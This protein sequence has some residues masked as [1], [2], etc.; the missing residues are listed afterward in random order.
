MVKNVNTFF[1]ILFAFFNMVNASVIKA[2]NIK[3]KHS[4]ISQLEWTPGRN[5]DEKTD[6]FWEN[7]SQEVNP[8]FNTQSFEEILNKYRKNF[9]IKSIGK[10]VTINNKLYPDI[11]NYVPNGFVESW[12]KTF[13]TSLR[14]I[15]QTRH[16]SP[17]IASCHDGVLDIDFNLINYEKFS[18]NPKVN[19]QSISNRGTKIGEGIS[20]GFKAAKYISPK[21]SFA[22]GG[23]NIIHF[24]DTIDLG[25]NFYLVSS[26]YIPFAKKKSDFPS[27]VFVNAGIGSDFFGYKGN[28]FL[29]TTSCLGKPTL[30]GEGTEKCNWG[31]IGSVAFVFNERFSLINEWFGYSYGT[32]FSYR[33]IKNSSLVLSLFATDFIKGYPRYASEGCPNNNCSTRYYGSFSLSI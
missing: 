6:L 15:N 26:T 7:S 28:G 9:S 33:P 4:Q 13:T 23:E 12:Q 32:G 30:T 17:E 16:C 29:G 1:V 19:I 31:P 24:D 8:N 27:M 18:F 21:W 22:F 14:A 5:I 2:E 11:S 3:N 10:S 25:R 20:L